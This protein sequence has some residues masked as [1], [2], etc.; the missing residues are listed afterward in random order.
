MELRT[1]EIDAIFH[2]Y[3]GIKSFGV[4]GG[5]PFLRPDLDDILKII[6]RTQRP[7]ILFVT[8]NG[9]MSDVIYNQVRA[10]LDNWTLKIK[11][12]KILISVDGPPAIHDA[13]RGVPGLFQ[14]IL[15][16]LSSMNELASRHKNLSVGTVT[17]YSPHNFRV[18][19]Q[20]LSYIEDLVNHYHLEPTFCLY[21]ESHYYNNDHKPAEYLEHLKHYLPRMRDILKMGGRSALATGRVMLWD[22]VEKW[23]DDPGR[24]VIPCKS[25]TVRYLIDPYGV[26][27]PCFI[28]DRPLGYL[29][30]LSYDLKRIFSGSVTKRARETIKMGGCHNCALTCELLPTMMSQP[31][32]TARR[33]I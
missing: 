18:F 20:V 14:H 17:L 13:E 23:L 32:K 4:T 12:L 7:K 3:Q 26:V 21:D 10:I 16:T 28:Y 29:R 30:D 22:M 24:Q 11:Q 19:D 27:Y 33:L 2:S 31:F 8:S 9:F 25:G 6:I 5:E 1:D 15:T